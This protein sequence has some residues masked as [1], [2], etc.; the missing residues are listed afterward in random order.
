M[1]CPMCN[2]R[3]LQAFIG[4]P[5]GDFFICADC[6]FEHDYQLMLKFLAKYRG[7]TETTKSSVKGSV[8]KLASLR[9]ARFLSTQYGLT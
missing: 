9:S 4:G 2:S 8:G 3:R 1:S 5:K 7:Q 6:S